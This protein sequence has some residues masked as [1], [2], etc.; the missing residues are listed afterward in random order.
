MLLR[1]FVLAWIVIMSRF[2][3]VMRRRLMF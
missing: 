1:V 3:V 2:A